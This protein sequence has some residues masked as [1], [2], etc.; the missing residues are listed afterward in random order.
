MGTI[1]RRVQILRRFSPILRNDSS[2]WSWCLAVQNRLSNRHA[3]SSAQ[4]LLT[5][6]SQIVDLSL[7]GSGPRRRKRTPRIE[8]NTGGIDSDTLRDKQKERGRQRPY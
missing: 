4:S 2:S 3:T 1:R 6:E 7:I 8:I 5:Q